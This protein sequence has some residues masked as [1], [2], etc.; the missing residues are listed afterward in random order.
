MSLFNPNGTYSL[1]HGG[2]LVE[3]KVKR[4]VLGCHGPRYIV[5]DA[6]TGTWFPHPIKP[7]ALTYRAA[8]AEGAA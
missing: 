1:F 8:S 6:A 4:I 2:R 7:E 5:A 3:I